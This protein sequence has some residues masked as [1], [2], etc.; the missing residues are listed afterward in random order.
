MKLTQENREIAIDSVARLEIARQIIRDC[1]PALDRVSMHSADAAA[2][3]ADKLHSAIDHL[4]VRIHD[5]E[6]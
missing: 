1:I 5:T 4:Y 2:R 3:A 6:E